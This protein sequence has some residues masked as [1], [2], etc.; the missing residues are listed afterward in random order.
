MSIEKR[1]TIL[2]V[3]PTFLPGIKYG[4]PIASV[5]NLAQNLSKDYNIKILTS[6][7]DLG[8]KKPYPAIIANTWLQKDNYQIFYMKKKVLS[9]YYLIRQINLTDADVLY[10]NSFFSPLFS[11]SIAFAKKIGVLKIKDLVIAPRGEFLS[12]AIKIKK[13]KKF[14]YLKLA[15]FSRLYRD[16]FWHA[17]SKDEQK[18]ITE[19]LNVIPD[20]IRVATNITNLEEKDS[21][22]DNKKHGQY[23]SNK[24]RVLRIV[25]LSRICKDKNLIYAL[26]VLQK[27]TTNTIFDIYGPIEDNDIWG[28]CQKEIEQMR[29]NI[30]VNYFGIVKR[31]D[32]KSIFQQ[33]DLFFLPSFSENFG[34]VIVESLS[35]GTSVLLSDKTPWRNLE[36]KGWGWDFS[37]ADKDKFVEVIHGMAVHPQSYFEE[38][39]EMIQGSFVKHLSNPEILNANKELFMLPPTPN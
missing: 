21:S 10:L 25:F 14:L 28:D 16:I 24:K 1:K 23:Y 20:K 5:L 26:E 34:H 13:F 32:V 7:R 6:D 29:L 18:S 33:Y 30:R 12:G 8:D 17:T 4:G 9:P 22:I 11:I 15:Y 36:E 39:R 27:I 2:M 31:E 38:R 19:L 3:V 35:V 37:L